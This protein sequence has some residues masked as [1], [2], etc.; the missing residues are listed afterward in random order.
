MK[1]PE[2]K[3]NEKR[4]KKII[5]VACQF[6]RSWCT[7]TW[8]TGANLPM[9]TS[10]E[11]IAQYLL[12]S[13]PHKVF[14]ENELQLSR[15]TVVDWSNF[16]RETL[17]YWSEKYSAKTLGG[18]DIV[19]EVEEAKFGKR[20]YN[21]GRIIEGTWLFSAIERNSK[22]FFVESVPSHDA[23]TLE[24]IIV[25][26]IKKGTIIISDCWKSYNRL[27]DLDR[28]PHTHTYKRICCTII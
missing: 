26:R 28:K 21:T 23:K 15:P 20:K 6:Y 10:C 1:V 24:E 17:L 14:L 25:R 13:P 19:V 8:F 9:T 4:N 5:K 12:L 18:Q 22:N 16:I 2:G 27:S 11:F 3:R 7:Y